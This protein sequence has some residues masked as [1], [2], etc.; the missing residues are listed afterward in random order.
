MAKSQRK[1]GNGGKLGRKQ[2]ERRQRPKERSKRP[3]EKEG[4]GELELKTVC[5]DPA[6]PRC[7]KRN[8]TGAIIYVHGFDD[9]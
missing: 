6:L 2:K 1:T 7:L 4:E 3:K 5:W 9:E 8:I